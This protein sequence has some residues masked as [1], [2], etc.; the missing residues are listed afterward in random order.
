MRI[1]KSSMTL[2]WEVIRGVV[3]M[4]LPLLP[5]GI[6]SLGWELQTIR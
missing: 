5:V 3:P 2:R 6:L 4:D 1:Q